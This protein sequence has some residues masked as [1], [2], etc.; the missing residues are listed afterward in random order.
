[1]TKLYGES[2]RP[3]R[4]I[5][6]VKFCKVCGVE[7]R[8]ARYSHI[9]AIGM[10][11]KCRKEAIRLWQKKWWGNLSE[12]RKKEYKKKRYEMWKKW[13]VKNLERRRKQALKSY[14]KNK[15]KHRNRRHR[16]TQSGSRS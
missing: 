10:C 8:P 15:D 12:E 1:M 6:I 7:Y 14:H 13:V 4:D 16:A 5:K 11:W 2:G 9:G 3:Y